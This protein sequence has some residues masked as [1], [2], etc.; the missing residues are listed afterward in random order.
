[1]IL[2]A[3]SLEAASRSLPKV[4][5]Q[6]IEELVERIFKSNIADGQLDE[7]P[8][9]MA[10]LAKIKESFIFTLINSLH[11]RIAYPGSKE[12]ETAPAKKTTNER[13]SE[14]VEASASQ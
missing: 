3:D 4:T 13:K 8:I 5:P 7:C 2:L 10:E 9:T 6:N 1:M 12:Q 11:T 14:R